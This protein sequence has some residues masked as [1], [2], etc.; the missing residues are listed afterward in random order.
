M[1]SVSAK[2]VISVV[3]LAY[4]HEN[5]IADALDSI[6]MQQVEARLEII[7]TED[8]STDRTRQIVES[9]Q[10]KYP[11]LFRMITRE[12]N[13][14]GKR[15]LLD[16]FALATGDFIAVLDGDDYWTDPQK[17]NLQIQ[18]LQQHQEC[19]GCGHNTR[20]CY[21]Q[22][23][24]SDT[25]IVPDARKK[26]IYHL[27]DFILGH[28][29][30]H[31][32]SLLFRNL[33]HETLRSVHQNVRLGDMFMCIL[34]ATKGDI[35]FIDR[36]MSTYRY[37]GKGVWSSIPPLDQ[38]M[39]TLESL[40]VGNATLEYQYR[41]WFDYALARYSASLIRAI[42]LHGPRNVSLFFRAFLLLLG[43]F[44]GMIGISFPWIQKYADCI[45]RF[46]L[47]RSTTPLEPSP[48]AALSIT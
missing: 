16:A 34:F 41:K 44:P 40:I 11:D 25:L 8:C 29:Y 7:V 47:S 42:M 35:G 4:N 38:R 39:A 10:T 23:Q 1:Q 2:P 30:L 21:Q 36:T 27:R 9:Y 20:V 48:Q 31:S 24:Q 37:T 13:V 15:N 6:L 19:A 32:S 3:V 14:G 28:I 26:R 12:K 46:I 45:D 33:L 22:A 43:H 5:Y 17:L 18:F